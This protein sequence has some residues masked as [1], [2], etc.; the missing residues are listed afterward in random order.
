MET[1]RKKKD[2]DCVEM[3]NAIQAKILAETENMTSEEL[4]AYF[5][6]P[7]KNTPFWNPLSAGV[8]K[9]APLPE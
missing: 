4:L 3:K 9:P 2:F 5:N 8:R 1:T 6:T 7:V